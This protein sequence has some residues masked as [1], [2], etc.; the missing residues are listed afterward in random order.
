LLENFEPLRKILELEQQKGY[1]DSAVIGGLDKFLRNWAAKVADSITSPRLLSRF[2]KLAKSGYASLDRQ[3][4]KEWVGSMLLFMAETDSQEGGSKP[5][6]SNTRRS[7]RAKPGAATGP[8]PAVVTGIGLDSPVTV[9]KGVSTGLAARFGKLGVRTVR[10][11]LYFFPHR[12]LDYS[13]VKF[14]SQL[15]EGEE[16]TIEANVWQSQ[17][18]MLGG[19]RGTEAIV[20]DETGNVR[21]VWFNQPY[22]AKKLATNTRIVLSGRVS[23]FKGHYVF[24]S[25]EW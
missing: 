24:E 13:Q 17:V 16:Q 1:S 15:A 4:R 20:G 7:S 2:R 22:L 5:T 25:P 3:Q 6:K 19:R 12:H 10:D 14:V 8:T 23:L 18:T 11:L 21:V 9:I